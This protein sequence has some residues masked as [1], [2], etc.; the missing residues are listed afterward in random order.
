MAEAKKTPEEIAS[1][2]EASRKGGEKRKAELEKV[3]DAD[4]KKI[5]ILHDQGVQTY[6]IAKE[7][8]KFVNNDTVGQVILTIRKHHADDYD[9]VENVNSTKGYSGV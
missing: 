4:E 6:A 3:S 7:V 1:N 5:L 9:E 2:D 8:Y